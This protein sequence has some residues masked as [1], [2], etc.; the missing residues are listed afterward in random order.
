MT[1]EIKTINFEPKRHTFAHIARRMGGDKPASRYQEGTLDVQATENFHYK[2]LWEPQFWHYDLQKTK[3]VMSDWYKPLD[4]RQ[5]YYA[6]Y[7]IARAN[8]HQAVDRNFTFVE[9]KRLLEKASDSTKAALLS[10][11]I[12]VRHVHWG[13]NMNMA[14]ITQRG[15]GT[16]ITAPCI[17]SAG[18]QLGMAQIMSRIGLEIDGQTG[19]GL[20]KAKDAWMNDK[21]WQGI[22]KLVE[23]T[24]VQRDWFEVYV[25]QVLGINGVILDGIYQGMD[26]VWKEAALPVSMLTEFMSDWSKE[27]AKWSHSVI[28]TV[29]AE[30]A[31]NKALVSA[32]AKNWID[33]AEAALSE[34]GTAFGEN[35]LSKTAAAK[36]RA[37]AKS[38]GL[39]V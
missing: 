9:D 31:E 38:L 35:D 19:D 20:D 8:M 17:F 3:V 22:R 30:S 16:A 4:P 24:L 23:N 5:F 12:P 25:A 28:K 10:G 7:N 11:L 33:R 14:E 26:N 1:V 2:P 15:Y 36:V 32:W 29:A 37:N 13:S 39:E 34:Y 27:E 6:T 21:A 18:D